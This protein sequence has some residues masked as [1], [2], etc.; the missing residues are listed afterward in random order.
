[1]V[2]R[3]DMLFD[4]KHLGQTNVGKVCLPIG[5]LATV[6]HLGSTYIFLGHKITNV[7]HI[8]EFRYNLLFVS[9]ITKELKGV[10]M[11]F[12]EFCIF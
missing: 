4:L 12:L 7:M 8:L 9:K 5:E 2:H 3:I 11:F 6:I 1:M 10:A